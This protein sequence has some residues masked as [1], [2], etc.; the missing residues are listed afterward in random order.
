MKNN[1][2]SIEGVSVWIVCVSFYLYEL[3]LRT[4]LGTF[5][6]PLMK[7]L[8]LNSFDFALL[9]STAYLLIYAVMQM[10]VSSIIKRFGIKFSML[11]AALVCAFASVG[12]SLCHSHATALLF[13]GLMGFG[14]AFGFIGMLVAVY[15]WLPY[16]NIAL[17]IGISQFLGTLG[18]MAAAGPLD[19][20]IHST[21]ISWRNCFYIYLTR[22]NFRIIQH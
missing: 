7:D 20:L 12:F 3:L 11:F 1:Q 15:D 18:P 16:K 8:N 6:E 2:L 13:R 9:S 19:T 17:F 4:I 10:P 5:Q 21:H 14:S 22:M